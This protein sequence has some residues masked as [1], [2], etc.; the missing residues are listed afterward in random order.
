[1]RIKK[2]GDREV[3]QEVDRLRKRLGIKAGDFADMAASSVRH[4]VVRNTQPFGSGPKPLAAGRGQIAYDLTRVFDVVPD[5]ARGQSGVI[6]SLTAAESW[7]QSRRG[8]RGRTTLGKKKKIIHSVFRMYLQFVW[9]QVGMAKGSVLGGEPPSLKG[10]FKQWIKRH[11]SGGSSSRRKSILGAVWTFKAEPEHVASNNVLGERGVKR[12]M[13]FKE[14]ALR[15][16]LRGVMRSELKKA[17][18]RVNR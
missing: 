13:K 8:K 5:A 12:A 11:K 14:R 3:R 18:R 15:T 9:K 1:V 17:E 4:T 10:R 7:H 2:L 16:K 6:T